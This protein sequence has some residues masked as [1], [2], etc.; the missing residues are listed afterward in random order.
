MA[1]EPALPKGRWWGGCPWWERALQA[2]VP[3]QGMGRGHEEEEGEGAMS[4]LW[5][6]RLSWDGCKREG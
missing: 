3:G 2:G 5:T 4:K 6:A 1:C